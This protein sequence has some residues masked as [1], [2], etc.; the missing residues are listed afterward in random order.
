MDRGGLQKVFKAIVLSCRIHKQV[1]IHTLR[2]C[3]GTA[4]NG[5]RIATDHG[6][7]HAAHRTGAATHRRPHQRPGGSVTDHPRR[8]CLSVDLTPPYRSLP[9]TAGHATAAARVTE[10]V[11][12]G[13]GLWLSARQR[14]RF[15]ALNSIA[16]AYRATPS[17]CQRTTVFPMLSM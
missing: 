17:H 15:I 14:K 13:Q 7:L 9:G 12:T 4:R 6:P 1:S 3:Y 5:A 16:L 11:S 10:R 2:H 8:E